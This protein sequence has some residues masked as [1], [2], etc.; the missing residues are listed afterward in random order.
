MNTDPTGAST[1]TTAAATDAHANA[2]L[3]FI[4]GASSGLGQALAA[5]YAR[6][7]WRLALVARRLSVMQ[8]W[9]EHLQLPPW[10][11]RLYAADVAE[12]ASIR[13]AAEQCLAQQGL[14][15]VVIASAGISHGIDTGCW[16]D[17]PAMQQIWQ[18]NNLGMAATFIPFIGPMRTRGSGSLVGVASVAG[19]RGLPGHAG[20]SA[21]KAAVLAYCESLR[22]DLRGSGV[23]VTTIS[24]GFIDTAMTR[25]NPFPMPFLMPADAFARQAAAAI[26][27]QSSYVVIPWQMGWLARLLRV[28][29]DWLFDWA[30]AGRGRKPRKTPGDGQDKGGPQ[31]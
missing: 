16:E 11:C 18:T 26:A 1:P 7:G 24:P 15:Q 6:Q 17:L 8:A 2:P 5:H 30:L 13:A 25:D 27:R 14:P 29:P 20:Y 12:P 19:V 28:L 9:C 10:Q 3:V 23:K 22:G 31:P 4:T 21:S